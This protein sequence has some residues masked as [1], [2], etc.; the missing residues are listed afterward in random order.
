MKIAVVGCGALGSFYGA[1]LSALGLDLR[2][3]LRSDYHIVA[4][5]GVRIES[6]HG[7]FTA[8]PVCARHPEEIGPCDLVLIGL[9]T[10][11]NHAFG[12]LIPPLIGPETPLL[13]LQNGLGNEE[14]LAAL[15]GPE[16][17]LGGLCFVCLNRIAPGVVRHTAHGDILLGEFGREPAARTQQYCDLFRSAGI[18]CNVVPNLERAHWEKLV[19]NIPFNGLGVAGAVGYDSVIA[20]AIPAD[21]D[22]GPCLPTDELLSDA[23]WTELIR[24]LMVEVVTVARR[25]GFDIPDRVIEDRIER[26]REMGRYKASTLI[27]FERGQPLELESLFIE[28]L[29]RAEAVGIRPVRLRA[30]CRVLWELD[31]RR[32]AGN[33]ASARRG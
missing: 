26:T 5:Q 8:H 16:R 15:F 32:N 19:W 17:V 18:R 28:P 12:R 24:E 33:R 31:Q 2:F 30:L 21:L 10:T 20:G 1:K 22:P 13:T 3:L 4:Q 11:A 25:L 14:Q 7:G 23:G 29:R 27:D 9:K 6:V